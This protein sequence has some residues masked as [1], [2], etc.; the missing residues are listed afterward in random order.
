MALGACAYLLACVSCLLVFPAKL[1]LHSLDVVRLAQEARQ[2]WAGRAPGA[3]MGV[4]TLWEQ[5]SCTLMHFKARKHL[6][7]SSLR[8]HDAMQ[9]GQ[10]L[11]ANGQPEPPHT[12]SIQPLWPPP[13]A[14]TAPAVS[15]R[16]KRHN[17]PLNTC[18]ASLGLFSS[19]MP[20]CLCAAAGGVGARSVRPT[21]LALLLISG[22]HA[23][24]A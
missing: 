10:P 13:K 17:A 23:Q 16:Q 19:C 1:T 7:V 8:M 9:N 15:A 21:R 12:S 6:I 22:G 18:V 14:A 11:K 20:R 24:H 2:R 4:W 5:R 3:W